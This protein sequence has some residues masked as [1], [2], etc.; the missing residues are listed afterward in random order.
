MIAELDGSGAQV[1]LFF[2]PV[3][4]LIY[5]DKHQENTLPD[6]CVK[7]GTLQTPAR[8]MRSTHTHSHTHTHTQREQTMK[9]AHVHW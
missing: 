6:M 2:Q 7:A 3:L 1:A 8:A 5:T 9:A 4:T